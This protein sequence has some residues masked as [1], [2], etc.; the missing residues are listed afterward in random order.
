M[1]SH[2]YRLKSKIY[3]SKNICMS[4]GCHRYFSDYATFCKIMFYIQIKEILEKINYFSKI[5]SWKQYVKCQNFDGG[6]SI[7]FEGFIL[8]IWVQ[9]SLKRRCK[10]MDRAMCGCFYLKPIITISNR[11]PIAEKTFCVIRARDCYQ[12]DQVESC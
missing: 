3:L 4:I 8:F 11:R 9:F 7:Y 2:S 5:I 12:K 10:L 1:H 6:N